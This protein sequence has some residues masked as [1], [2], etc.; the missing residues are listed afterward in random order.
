MNVSMLQSLKSG[1]HERSVRLF[2]VGARDLGG[3]ESTAVI[4]GALHGGF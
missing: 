3:E 2:F 4:N 1:T